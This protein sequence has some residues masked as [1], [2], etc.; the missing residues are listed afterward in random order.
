MVEEN[1]RLVLRF[2]DQMLNRQ[3]LAVVDEVLSP[4]YID[5]DA[6]PGQ[7]V[8][9]EGVK[10]TFRLVRECLEDFKVATDDV[11]AEG[12]RVVMRLTAEATHVGPFLGFTATGNRLKWTAIS[13]YRIAGGKI[14]E[15]WGLL[16]YRSLERQLASVGSEG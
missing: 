3:N 16:D 2:V 9:P 1:K 14:A 7:P 10:Q 5:H 15:R 6:P 13:I 8:G 11:I 12:D 4:D